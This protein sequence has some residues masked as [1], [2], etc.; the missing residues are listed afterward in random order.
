MPAVM[1]FVD[2]RTTLPLQRAGMDLSNSFPRFKD[3]PSP[4][5]GLLPRPPDSQSATFS[6]RK[7]GTTTSPVA[8]TS[9]VTSARKAGTMTPVRKRCSGV[10]GV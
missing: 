6:N 8:G 4:G 1:H 7:S 9:T 10:S 3:R 2:E 5:L